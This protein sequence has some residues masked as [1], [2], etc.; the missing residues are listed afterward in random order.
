VTWPFESVF[1][2]RHGETQWNSEG[3]RQGQL[4]SPLTAT[5]MAQA[6]SLADFVATAD[7]DMIFTSPLGRAHRTA[8][9][10]GDRSHI[11]VQVVTELSEIHHGEFAGLTN[12]EIDAHFPGVLEQRAASKYT[13]RFPGGDSYPDADPPA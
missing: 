4:D 9:T 3:R 12:A 8:T 11:D 1:I 10:A 13:W 5:G 2:A 6:E 7:V